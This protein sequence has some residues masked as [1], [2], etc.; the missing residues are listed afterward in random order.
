[1]KRFLCSGALAALVL[2]PGQVSAAALELRELALNVNGTRY[3]SVLDGLPV[4][5]TVGGGTISGSLDTA[6]G[7]GTLRVQVSGAGVH[8]VIGFFDVDFVDGGTNTFFD[9]TGGVSGAPGAGLS[10]EID[11]PGFAFGDIFDHVSNS[12]AGNNLLTKTNDLPGPEDVSLA[13][14]WDFI[15]ALGE[16]AFIDF[17]GTTTDPGGFRLAVVDPSQ[18]AYYLRS[19]LRIEGGGQPPIPEPGTLLLVGAGA[20]AGVRRLRARRA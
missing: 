15:L 9:E 10:W 11:E 6:T 16:T 14:G 4:P 8:T 12:T 18:Q 5:G 2:A 19:T 7:L 1:M 13:L 3:D 20:A 17:I